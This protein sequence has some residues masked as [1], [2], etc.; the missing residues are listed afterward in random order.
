MP[1]R[2]RHPVSVIGWTLDRFAEENG[3]ETWAAFDLHPE[4]RYPRFRRLLPEVRLFVMTRDPREA[5]AA[6]L[7]WRGDPDGMRDAQFKHRL[8]LWC[9]SLQTGRR[10]SRRWPSH[11]HVGDFSALVSGDLAA[12][13]QVAR[14]FGVG[15]D[16]VDQA[17]GF[18]PHFQFDAERGFLLPDGRRV[19]LLSAVE[20]REISIL[21]SREYSTGI[22]DVRPRWR[23]LFLARAVLALGYISP[24][25]SRAVADLVY[26]PRRYILR[27]FNGV[28]RLVADLRLAW[29]P[30][31]SSKDAS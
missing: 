5:I 25:F 22:T 2:L 14:C 8:I 15:L 7:F 27:R 4:F 19:Q 11:V 9:L 17:Y 3:G 1:E 20:L 10:L 26:Y 13:Q 28:R 24:G 23:F 12:R 29:Y 6:A 16:V 21:T 18:T 30:L 31:E